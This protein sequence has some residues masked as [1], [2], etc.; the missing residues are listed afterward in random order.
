VEHLQHFKLAEDPFRS[1]PLEKFDTGLPSQQGALARL[2]RGVR[3]GKGLVLLLGGVGAGKSR[4][5]RRLYDDLEE[6]IFEAGMMMVLR[7]Q[8]DP[9]WLLTRFAGQLGVEEPAP[10]HEVIIGQIYERLAIIHEDGRRAVLIIDDA[11]ALASSETLSEVCALVKLEYE[12]RRLLTVVLAGAPSLDATVRRDPLLAHHVDVKVH[13][14]PLSRDEAVDYLSARIRAAGGDPQI[15]LP[16]AAA[17]LHELSEGT[18]GRLNVLADNALYEAFVARR[19][20][21]TRSDVERAW[22][23]LGWG[24]VGDAEAGPA[25]APPVRRSRG[26]A[27][28]AQA[29][30][31]ALAEQTMMATANDSEATVRGMAPLAQADAEVD[32]VFGDPGA[33]SGGMDFDAGPAPA[34]PRGRA[35]AAPTEV[36]LEGEELDGPPK[37]GDEVDDL[38]MELLDD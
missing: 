32:A 2:D 8:H 23:D 17:A 3:Q 38:F 10:Q 20:Q 21:M 29:E 7:R 34:R 12:D 4:V 13:L 31:A 19:N 22:R 25:A 26:G 18:P 15:V 9:A 1:D 6:E 37:E 30:R 24:H 11:H 35:M 27:D 33:S 28:P 36:S 14:P 5:A 16:G